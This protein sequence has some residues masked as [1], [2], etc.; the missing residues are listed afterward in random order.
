MNGAMTQNGED[1]ERCCGI[2]G[3]K[4]VSHFPRRCCEHHCFA[5]AMFLQISPGHVLDGFT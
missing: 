4:S 2:F 3:E 5:V 1:F